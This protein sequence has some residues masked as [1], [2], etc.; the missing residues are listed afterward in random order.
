MIDS[1]FYLNSLLTIRSEMESQTFITGD[2]KN[3]L[4]ECLFDGGDILKTLKVDEQVADVRSL[5]T[6]L[7]TFN[8]VKLKCIIN[9]LGKQRVY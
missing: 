8:D 5:G 6:E 3:I 2:N 4:L 9:W 1:C 7:G